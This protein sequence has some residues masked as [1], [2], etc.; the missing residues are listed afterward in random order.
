MSVVG[1]E[2][3]SFAPTEYF[4]FLT[5]ERNA[6]DRGSSFK[7]GDYKT[8][9]NGLGVL[10]TDIRTVRPPTEGSTNFHIVIVT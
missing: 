1:P 10:R 6:H 8:E 4:A 3:T 2:R 5:Q 7:V 9:F